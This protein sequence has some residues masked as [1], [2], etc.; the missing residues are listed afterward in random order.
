MIFDACH[1]GAAIPAILEN[2]KN[3]PQ[4][5]ELWFASSGTER[6]QDVLPPILPYASMVRLFE[7]NQ[8]GAC[9][10]DQL[11]KLIPDAF[12]GGCFSEPSKGNS[13]ITGTI[14]EKLYY[15]GNGIDLLHRRGFCSSQRF[16]LQNVPAN[17]RIFGKTWLI[18]LQ[19]FLKILMGGFLAFIF[20]T[21]NFDRSIM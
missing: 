19:I 21:E 5:V 3:L 10:K 9:T 13:P 17:F 14:T 8:P 11:K 6:A 4:P 1:N 12:S 18:L 2:L 20:C 16:G 15:L 7:I